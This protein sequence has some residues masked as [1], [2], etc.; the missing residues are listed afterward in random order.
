M[1]GG[2]REREEILYDGDDEPEA[3]PGC[4]YRRNTKGDY[5]RKKTDYNREP[6]EDDCKVY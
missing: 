1:G 2:G 6:K 4:S 3:V 5:G